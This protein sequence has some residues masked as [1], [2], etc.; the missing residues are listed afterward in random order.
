MQQPCHVPTS[1][2]LPAK[3]PPHDAAACCLSHALH[4]AAAAGWLDVALQQVQQRDRVGQPVR[5]AR[6]VVLL[7]LYLAA[8][9]LRSRESSTSTKRSRS[10]E[11]DS[12][13]HVDPASK[14]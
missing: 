5:Q 2:R 14:L 1:H 3:Q 9:D 4:A 13:A 6:I 11:L 12:V 10:D 7:P 8:D